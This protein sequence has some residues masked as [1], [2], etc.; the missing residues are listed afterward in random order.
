MGAEADCF[1]WVV[2]QVFDGEAGEDVDR[3]G[4]DEDDRVLPQADTF[5]RVEDLLEQRDIAVDQIEPAFVRL[6]AEASGDDHHVAV[7]AA[8]VAAGVDFLIAGDA[9]AVE[10]VE[11]LAG[12]ELLVGVE[13]VDFADDPGTLQG[14]RRVGA[15]PAAAAD[16]GDF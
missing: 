3:V 8:V 6:S 9:G 14:K 4:N 1:G 5:E 11:G 13:Q 10:E 2:F 12:G 16:D 15:D 7:G